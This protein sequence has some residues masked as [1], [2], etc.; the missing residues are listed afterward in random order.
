[1]GLD[2]YMHKRTYVKRWDHQEKEKKHSVTVLLGNSPH[3]D[4]DP[5]KISNVE[6][7]IAYWRK[8]NHIHKWFVDNVQDG[9]DDCGDYYVSSD[10]L[11]SL[12]EKCKEVLSDRSKARALLPTKSG[13]FF[14]G[15]EYDEYYFKDCEDTITMLE[16]YIDKDKT[17]SFY[18]TSSW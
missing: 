3:P 10:Q 8:A 6:E 15:T 9:K 16:P 4:I 13:F 1:M 5:E 7:E 14:G 11:K 12:I 2:M 17:G 18:Y